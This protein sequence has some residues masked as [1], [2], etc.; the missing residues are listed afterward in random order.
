MPIQNSK[1]LKSSGDF[2][3]KHCNQ[4][5]ALKSKIKNQHSKIK[6]LMT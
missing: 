6:K 3:N 2:E 4:I 5:K 1:R